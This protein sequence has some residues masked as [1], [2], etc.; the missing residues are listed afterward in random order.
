MKWQIRAYCKNGVNSFLRDYSHLR[1]YIEGFLWQRGYKVKDTYLTDPWDNSFSV[2]ISNIDDILEVNLISNGKFEQPRLEGFPLLNPQIVTLVEDY[3]KTHTISWYFLETLNGNELKSINELKRKFEPFNIKKRLEN[4]NEPIQLQPEF[5]ERVS[6]STGYHLD[7]YFGTKMNFEN[8]VNFWVSFISWYDR[9]ECEFNDL[10]W[11]ID[12][13]WFESEYGCCIPL[14][15]QSINFDFQ[16]I[17]K[18]FKISDLNASYLMRKNL[19]D[20]IKLFDF[21][22]FYVIISNSRFHEYS[23]VQTPQSGLLQFQCHH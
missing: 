14:N 18:Q 7:W 15:I 11:L 10:S 5:C 16:S 1:R 23:S 4:Q 22:D 19:D 20:E 9:G 12:Q 13:G 17:K 8:I 21:N 3:F 2:D 6:S